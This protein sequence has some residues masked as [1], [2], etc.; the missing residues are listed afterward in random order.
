[1]DFPSVKMWRLP[2]PLRVVVLC[3]PL[4]LLACTVPAPQP[5]ALQSPV[6][7]P[8]HLLIAPPDITVRFRVPEATS[9]LPDPKRSAEATKWATQ[10]LQEYWGAEPR[11][12]LVPAEALAEPHLEEQVG[13]YYQVAAQAFEIMASRDTRWRRK[14]SVP[15]FSIGPGLAELG[16]RHQAQAILFV[17]G[18]QT[19][20]SFAMQW[21]RGAQRV[22]PA[23]T[24]GLVDLSSGRLVWL[25]H[26]QPNGS[27]KLN[28]E[29]H[30]QSL[31]HTLLDELS[32]K[33]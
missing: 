6:A 31:L 11:V 32:G 27:Q 28:Q 20:S 9:I 33:D 29:H 30:I 12:T 23:L 13:L 14:K 1:M 18:Q 17:V 10:V 24:A 21:G 26:V 3:L 5:H 16:A 8:Q 4:A 7:L 2:P 25:S 15:D 19:Q 22:P